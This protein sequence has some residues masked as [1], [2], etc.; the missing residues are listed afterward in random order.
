MTWRCR[1]VDCRRANTRWNAGMK[2]SERR[3]ICSIRTRISSDAKIQTSRISSNAQ[4][5]SLTGLNLAFWMQRNRLRSIWIVSCPRTTTLNPSSN[6]R[7]PRKLMNWK[8]GSRKSWRMPNKTWQTFMSARL[9]IWRSAKTSK[10][11][12]LG[13]SKAICE[14]RPK[15]TKMFSSS[16]G[17]SK[18]AVMSKLE[19]LSSKWGPN[20]IR[21]LELS[22]YTRT[23]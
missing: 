15:T 21:S 20:R 6:W 22:T 17:R 16:S 14:T 4:K 2:V 8:K 23:T 1:T 10:N 3:L 7:T 18:K 19:N 9:N 12:V 5:I 11:L 13:N